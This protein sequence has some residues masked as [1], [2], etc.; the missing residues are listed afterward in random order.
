MARTIINDSQFYDNSAAISAGAIYN[1]GL[2]SVASSQFEGNASQKNG[3]A[4]FND[5]Q[6]DVRVS[7]SF[8]PR[9]QRPGR[10][11]RANELWPSQRQHRRQRLPR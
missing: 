3:G 9:Q 4:I 7:D 10:R 2:L 1:L 11:R 8:F 5:Y 6:A